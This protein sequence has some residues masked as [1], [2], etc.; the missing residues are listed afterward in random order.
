M[1][2]AYIYTLKSNSLA[3][4]LLTLQCAAAL[5]L[6]L[7]VITAQGSVENADLEDYDLVTC[8]TRDD[9]SRECSFEPKAVM[10]CAKVV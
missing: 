5:K 6:N 3:I 9:E 10:E 2:G 7:P 1:I 4:M 8:K